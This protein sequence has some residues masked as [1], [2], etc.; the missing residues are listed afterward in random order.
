M[1]PISEEQRRINEEEWKR[2]ENWSD[3]VI[4][5]YFAKRDTRTWVPKRGRWMGWTLNLAHPSGARWMLGF[6]VGL[7]LLIL[8]IVI[9]ALNP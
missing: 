3:R 2:E 7:P 9:L 6:L 1:A 8:L 4:G 5:F